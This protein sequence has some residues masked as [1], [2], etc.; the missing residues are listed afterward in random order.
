MARFSRPV[1]WLPRI[2]AGTWL[3]LP[4]PDVALRPESATKARSSVPAE[5]VVE[6]VRRAGGPVSANDVQ[7]ALGISLRVAQKRLKQ[8]SDENKL[9]REKKGTAWVYALR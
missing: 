8:L 4:I 6:F 1:D 9:T 2:P 3:T 5:D 7:A